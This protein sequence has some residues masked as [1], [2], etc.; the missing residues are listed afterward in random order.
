MKRNGFTV[1]ETLVVIAL[2]ITLASVLVLGYYGL[3]D[4]ASRHNATMKQAEDRLQV[5]AAWGRI[6]IDSERKAVEEMRRRQPS[7][8]LPA[9]DSPAG[10]ELVGL[11][12]R[13]TR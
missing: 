10:A 7:G 5:V 3:R 11:E 9:W 8:D 1:I 6:D 4:V 13:V 12:W 2:M